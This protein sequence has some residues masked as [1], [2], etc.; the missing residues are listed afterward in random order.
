MSLSIRFITL[1][2]SN[3]LFIYLL[4]ISTDNRSLFAASENVGKKSIKYKFT[5]NELYVIEKITD[6]KIKIYRV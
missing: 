4:S 2:E 1:F 6:I 3:F 5:T